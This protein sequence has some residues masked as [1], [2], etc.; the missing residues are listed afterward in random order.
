[1]PGEYQKA[2]DCYTNAIAIEPEFAH[3]FCNLGFVRNV[4]GQYQ[5]AVASH[6]RAFAIKPDYADAQW[7]LG[8]I[9]LRQGKY[10]QAWRLY[11]ARYAVGKTDLQTLPLPNGSRNCSAT[12][13]ARRGARWSVFV[14]LA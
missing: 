9:L 7:N 5:S 1:L 14:G 11:E 10:A 3:A 4:L 2:V 13:L 12:A 6:E 8:L